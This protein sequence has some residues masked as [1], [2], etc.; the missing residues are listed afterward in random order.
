MQ[1]REGA[2]SQRGL[3]RRLGLGAPRRLTPSDRAFLVLVSLAGPK[4][5]SCKGLSSLL[6]YSRN[7]E[8]QRR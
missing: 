4:T 5:S 1:A 8:T 3:R 6:L 7:H 2:A